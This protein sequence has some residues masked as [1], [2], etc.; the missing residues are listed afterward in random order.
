MAHKMKMKKQRKPYTSIFKEQFVERHMRLHEMAKAGKS[1]NF[2]YEVY[3]DHLISFD[4]E[5]QEYPH[6]HAFIDKGSRKFEVRIAAPLEKPEDTA[7]VKIHSYVTPVSKRKGEVIKQ[8]KKEILTW[9]LKK[10]IDFAEKLHWESLLL[11]WN[12]QNPT[13]RFIKKE[14]ESRYKRA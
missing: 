13:M 5:N 3:T 9:F 14:N 2:E 7:S 11:L 6:F 4:N 8:D 12:K 1:A 10:D